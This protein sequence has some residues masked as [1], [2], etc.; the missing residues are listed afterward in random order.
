MA[1][2]CW[3]NAVSDVTA[4]VRTHRIAEAASAWRGFGD[5]LSELVEALTRLSAITRDG[6]WQGEAADAYR[7]YLDMFATAV[8][9]LRD[10]GEVVANS[11]DR[12]MEHVGRAV[13]AIPVP[14]EDLTGGN[15]FGGTLPAGRA[16]PPMDF[17]N[18]EAI[19]DA[20]SQDRAGGPHY[21]ERGGFGQAAHDRRQA[22]ADVADAA[23]PLLRGNALRSASV[24]AARQQET[25]EIARWWRSNNAHAE[26]AYENVAGAYRDELPRCVLDRPAAELPA[27]PGTDAG[28]AGAG[29]GASGAVPGGGTAG[30]TGGFGG[31][32]GGAAPAGVPAACAPGT[33][34]GAVPGHGSLLGAGNLA[35]HGIGSAYGPSSAASFGG[36]GGSLPAPA[37][38]PMGLFSPG[39]AG[40]GPGRAPKPPLT[41]STKAPANGS[42]AWGRGGT[43]GGRGGGAG[44]P[45]AAGMGGAARGSG[46]RNRERFNEYVFDDENVFAAE[47]C[48]EGPLRSSSGYGM[49]QG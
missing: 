9:D 42:G 38:P 30:G 19:A 25:E 3:E 4:H 20:V 14:V 28:A 7:A 5:R 29:A 23:A 27:A 40:V 15:V 44:G 22:R 11:V 39:G 48:T 32:G 45:V 26:Y 18:G 2:L 1:D 24:P 13:N 16:L 17:D 36:G 34:T 12:C 31:L 6:G 10:R 47:E 43:G 35:P 8:G 33:Y 41:S 49:W 37:K 21:Y 46:E